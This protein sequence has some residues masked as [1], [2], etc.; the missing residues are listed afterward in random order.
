MA[1]VCSIFRV[2]GRIGN[3]IF[4]ERN[5]KTYARSV[6]AAVKNPNTEKQQ[7]VRDRFRVAVRFYQRLK[8]TPLEKVWQ[9]SGRNVKLTGFA[10]FMSVN[11][12]IFDH[13]GKIVDHEGLR[14]STGNRDGEYDL[15]ASVDERDRVTLRW[16]ESVDSA[17]LDQD[18]RLMVVLLHDDRAFSPEVVEGVQARRGD[19]TAT[20]ALHR[21]K[22]VPVHVYCFFVSPSFSAFSDSQ[23]LLV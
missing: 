2:K 16:A 12:R 5:G 10:L 3:T 11:L 19:R 8:E 18:D 21:K 17:Y 14:L 4:S 15:S 7:A 20:F 13:R 22:G 9:R 6:P 1:E 23:H